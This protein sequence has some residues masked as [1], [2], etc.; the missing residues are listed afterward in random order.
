MKTS[1]GRRR[2]LG[3]FAAVGSALLLSFAHPVQASYRP[4][5][6]AS[7]EATEL[8][9]YAAASTR[10]ALT[11]IQKRYAEIAPSVKLVFNFGSSG[12]L[13]KQI[14]AAAKADVFL[15][16]DEKEMDRVAAEKL[17]LD[18]TRRDLLSNQLVV[19]EPVDSDHPEASIFTKPFTPNQL[20]RPEVKLLS[21]A[22][23][24]SVPAGR[25]AKA[26]LEKTGTWNNVS[27]RVLPGVDVRAALGAVEAAGAQ[28]GIVYKTDVARS[29][30][31]RIVFAV[32]VSEGPRIIYPV[33]VI[34][35]RPG[36]KEARAFV[37][38]LA[39]PSGRESFQEFGFVFPAPAK[40]QPK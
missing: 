37:D 14:I 20:A 13:S 12:D 7:A 23:V 10:D 32:P 22:N 26:W 39:S 11:A 18:G 29:K 8:T 1:V 38:Y 35:G 16:A 15:S 17:V 27:E 31:A 28:A 9:I 24:E 21:L 3:S 19:I 34:A 30:K 4:S 5:K 33:A 2:F 6:R 40:A 36:E 25:Y